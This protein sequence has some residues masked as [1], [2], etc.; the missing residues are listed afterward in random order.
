MGRSW[1]AQHAEPLWC[2]PA[3]VLPELLVNVIDQEVGGSDNKDEEGE[4]KLVEYSTDS[5]SDE[6]VF[7][8]D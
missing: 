6:C 4:D 1:L 5:N 3:M 8:D 2:D 7:G